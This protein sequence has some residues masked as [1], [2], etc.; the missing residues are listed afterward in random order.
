[1]VQSVRFY[2]KTYHIS[3]VHPIPQNLFKTDFEIWIMMT[4]FVVQSAFNVNK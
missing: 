2:G 3:S 4:Y 1:L